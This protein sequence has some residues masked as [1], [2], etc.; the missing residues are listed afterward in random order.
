MKVMSFNTQHCLNYIEQKIDFDIMA[1]AILETG[2]DIVGLQEMRGTGETSEYQEQVQILANLTGM[3]YY[4]FDPAIYFTNLGPYGNGFLSKIP[5]VKAENVF[6]PDPSPRKYNGYYETRS[7]L[8]I[9]LENGV[10]VLVTHFGLNLDEQE[11]AVTTLLQ[12][13]TS[14]K[15]VVMGDFNALPESEV[16]KPI[17]EKLVD[18]AIKFD[19]EKLS[20]PSDKP[21][22]KIDYIFVSSD[23]EIIDADIPNIVASDHRPHV[24]TIKIKE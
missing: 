21:T 10:T 11:N 13:V 1:K 20:H 18:T 9:L 22:M 17:R 5:I 12:N 4:Y 3:K 16:L 19:K 14:E 24:A 6:I 2:A 8:K 23:I 15:C 7:V